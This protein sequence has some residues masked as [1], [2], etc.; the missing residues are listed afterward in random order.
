MREKRSGRCFFYCLLIRNRLL[1]KKVYSQKARKLGA[2]D[3]LWQ[4]NQKNIKKIEKSG[5][6]T[7]K[8]RMKVC[9][10]IAFVLLVCFSLRIGYIQF[11]M[12]SKLKS[13]AYIQQ[14]LDRKINPKR[15]TI[16]DAT[17]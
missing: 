3:R 11:I 6:L 9:L 10:I 17:R 7:R 12:G 1:R 16:Y 2:F 5:N 8:K 15:G 4:K 14:T 13:M